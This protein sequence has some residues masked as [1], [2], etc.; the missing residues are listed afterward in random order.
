MLNQIFVLFV[1]LGVFF[2]LC[3]CFM[4]LL[5]TSYNSFFLLNSMLKLMLAQLFVVVSCCIWY[6]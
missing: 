6:F 2:A 1:N 3:L 4:L 5:E